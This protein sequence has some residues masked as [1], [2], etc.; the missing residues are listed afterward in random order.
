V[1]FVPSFHRYE[2]VCELVKECTQLRQQIPLAEVV[3]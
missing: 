3:A 1:L 2:V